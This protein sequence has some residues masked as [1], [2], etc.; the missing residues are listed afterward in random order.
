M[1]Y[2]IAKERI[3]N[4]IIGTINDIMLGRV[5]WMIN[6]I[7]TAKYDGLTDEEVDRMI[8]YLNGFIYKDVVVIAFRSPNDNLIN[9]QLRSVT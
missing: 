6:T 4:N 5:S 2:D 7:G 9:Y 3:K 8:D 1:I